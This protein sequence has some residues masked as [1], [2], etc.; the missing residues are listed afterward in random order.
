MG[1]GLKDSGPRHDKIDTGK[2]EESEGEDRSIIIAIIK[3]LCVLGGGGCTRG[4]L[5]IR[6]K[7]KR[8]TLSIF[9]VQSRK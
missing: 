7:A 3:L 2:W 9:I 6:A 5:F 4:F 8:K 1:R